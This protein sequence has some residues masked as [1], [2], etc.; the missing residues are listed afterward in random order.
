[1]NKLTLIGVSTEP[2]KS[3]AMITISVD[4]VIETWPSSP[5]RIDIEI[6]VSAKFLKVL[7]VF[8]YECH[9]EDFLMKRVDEGLIT[10][11]NKWPGLGKDA[12]TIYEVVR[13]KMPR[14]ISKA[15]AGISY[16]WNAQTG[17]IIESQNIE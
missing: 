17:E 11:R 3:G 6:K 1:M 15:C 16:T 8:G 7:E 2:I 14:F 4:A 10:L 5:H 13:L 12:N 9:D